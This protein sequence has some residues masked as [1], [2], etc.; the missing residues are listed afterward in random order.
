MITDHSD[1]LL[2]R[3]PEAATLLAISERHLWSLTQ[4]RGPIPTTK[5]PGSRSVRYSRLALEEWVAGHQSKA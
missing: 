1:K 3:T 2:L 5:I 4:P